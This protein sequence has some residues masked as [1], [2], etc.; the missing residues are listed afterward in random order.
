MFMIER[1]PFLLVFG[2]LW[3]V[4][5]MNLNRSTVW[6]FMGLSVFIAFTFKYFCEVQE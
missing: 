6:Y 3:L 5:L 4:L 2:M 1:N